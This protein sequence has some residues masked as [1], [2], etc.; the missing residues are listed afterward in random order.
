MG[1]VIFFFLSWLI[2][3]IF[4]F[5][6]KKLS[7]IE[8]TFIFLIILIASINFSWIVIDEF[9]LI[10]RTKEGF[11]YTGYLLNR[12]V[13]IPF[14]ILIQF[15]LLAAGQ[16]LTKKGIIVICSV[17][18]FITFSFLSNLLN[19]TDYKNW[20]Y[21]YDIVYFIFLDLL[22]IIAYRLFKRASRNEVGY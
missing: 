4:S 22:T 19:I 18:L 15:N 14:L 9:Q 16:T 6:Q 3:L 12:S 7:L 10:I 20:H 1:F 8:N 13:I 17:I 11:G 21:G 2:I 5:I